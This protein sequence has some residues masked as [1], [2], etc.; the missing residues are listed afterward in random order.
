MAAFGDA[1]VLLFPVAT[2]EG[3]MWVTCPDALR[4]IGHEIN[5][6]LDNAV[7]QEGGATQPLNLGWLLL[8]RKNTPPGWQSMAEV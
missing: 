8:E 1:H 5:G 4:R 7:Y 2:R 3:P 6:S